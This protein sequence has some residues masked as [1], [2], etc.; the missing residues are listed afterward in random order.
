MALEASN[1]M[2]NQLLRDND[3]ASMAHTVELRVPFVDWHALSAIAPV[4]HRLQGRAGKL[5]LGRSPSLPLPGTS[6]ERPRSGFGVPL[7]AWAGG[8]A[9]NR[10]TSRQWAPRVAAQFQRG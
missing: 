9:I 10:L 2:R 7:S 1:Y 8:N 3:W 5:A 4:A 6:L